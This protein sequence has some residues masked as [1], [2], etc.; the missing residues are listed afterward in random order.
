MILTIYF[1]SWILFTIS[2]WVFQYHH[3]LYCIIFPIV[4]LVF[5]LCFLDK[6]IRQSKLC[7]IATLVWTLIVIIFVM[8]LG[9]NIHGWN[10]ITAPTCG[11][12]LCT[13]DKRSYYNP[14]ATLSSTIANYLDPVMICPVT[15]CRWASDNGLPALGYNLDFEGLID[16]NSPN[17]A[18]ATTRAEDYQGNKGRGFKN[19]YTEG[20]TMINELSPCPGVSS[21][22]ENG[23][24][25]KGELICAQCSVYV[26]GR[27]NTKCNDNGLAYICFLCPTDTR[28][29]NAYFWL[30]WFYYW[31]L[32]CIVS[33]ILHDTWFVFSKT[34]LW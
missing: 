2:A 20:V 8:A 5:L 22:L 13:L 27:A 29:F 33:I 25:G 9:S 16:Y 12:S 32:V 14:L 31:A 19:G 24:I 3:V 10:V 15:E 23:V 18:Y 21:Q 4:Y 7:M 26:Y 28:T 34:K 30:A 17:G 1:I 11:T 6:A